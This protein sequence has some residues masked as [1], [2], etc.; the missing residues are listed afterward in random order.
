MD[1]REARAG[2]VPTGRELIYKK[3]IEDQFRGVGIKVTFFEFS[4]ERIKTA[5]TIG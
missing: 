4:A 5:R 1:D 2:A 3:Q